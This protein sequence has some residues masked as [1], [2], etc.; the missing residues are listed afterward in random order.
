MTVCAKDHEAAMTF[1][2]N[3]VPDTAMKGGA[4][5]TFH[6]SVRCRA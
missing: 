3:N 6:S 5:N 4:R 1:R 2:M